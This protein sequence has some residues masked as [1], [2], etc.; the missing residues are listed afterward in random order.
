VLVIAVWIRGYFVSE[1]I[2]FGLPGPGGTITAGGFMSGRGGL[3]FAAV[4]GLP[5]Q[6]EIDGPFYQRERSAYAGGIGTEPAR[7]QMLGFRYVRLPN[8][9]Y[10]RG[11]AVAVPLWSLLLL[12]AVWPAWHLW[13]VRRDGPEKRRRRGLCAHC[14]Y[15]LRASAERCPECGT[16][17]AQSAG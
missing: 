3:G 9:P 13:T 6:K 1:T 7:W 14:G 4:T 10:G 15:D 11:W 2:G 5:Y 17:R 8:S 12:L 16:A